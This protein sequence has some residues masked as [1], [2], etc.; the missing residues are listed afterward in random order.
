[1]IQNKLLQN[2][3]YKKINKILM[4]NFFFGISTT[5]KGEVLFWIELDDYHKQAIACLLL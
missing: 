1:V 2:P 3:K 4:L 5:A